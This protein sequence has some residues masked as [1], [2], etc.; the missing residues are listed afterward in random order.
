MFSPPASGINLLE[1]SKAPFHYSCHSSYKLQWH[2]SVAGRNSTSD[3]SGMAAARHTDASQQLGRPWAPSWLVTPGISKS[4][5][6][7]E[8]PK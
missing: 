3:T 2:P 5:R 6:V 8:D 1:S 4:T 7:S